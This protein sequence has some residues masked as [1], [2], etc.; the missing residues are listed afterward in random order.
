VG[1]LLKWTHERLAQ[2][3]IANARVDAEHLLAHA[4]GC[5]R[6]HLYLEH[7]RPVDDEPRARFREYVKRR[8]AREPVA[9]I[10]GRRGFHALGLELAVDRRVLVPRP[11]TEHLVDWLLEDLREIT[12][13]R[14]LDV[15]T[16]S[17]AIALAV[18]HARGDAEVSA[19]DLSDDALAVARANAER[20]GERVTFSRSD[21]L[22]DA[23]TEGGWHA[24]A[25]NLP[26]IPT[27][28]IAGLDPEVATHEPRIALDGGDDG[29][30]VVARLLAQ[31]RERGALADGGAIYLELGAGQAPTVMQWLRDAGMSADVRSDY[32]QIPRV[33]R[34]RR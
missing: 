4:L 7:D 2:A 33:V 5:P 8:L 3:G 1:E 13:P 15:G 11:E 25:A 27:A 29:L 24:I 10:E 31:V 22:V 16:G 14:V 23:A 19:V 30:R 12:A 9:Y 6:M 34:G 32:A 18:A 20:L 21:L 17:G 26:Y 28:E